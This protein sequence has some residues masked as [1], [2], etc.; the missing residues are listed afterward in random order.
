M[1]RRG[2]WHVKG[3]MVPFLVVKVGCAFFSFP[4][5]L[6][7]PAGCQDDKMVEYKVDVAWLSGSTW[8]TTPKIHLTG[9]ICTGLDKSEK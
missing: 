4:L 3:R 7:L 6:S 8:G 5:S 1:A 9:T 2:Q